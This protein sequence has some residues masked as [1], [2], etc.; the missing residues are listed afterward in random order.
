MIKKL[1]ALV[2]AAV[3][4]V[5]STGNFIGFAEN[6]ENNNIAVIFDIDGDGEVTAADA[7]VTLRHA[8]RIEEIVIPEI[9]ENYDK[10]LGDLN[11]DGEIDSADARLLLR[12][13]AKLETE[14]DIIQ[15]YFVN[16]PPKTTGETTAEP[17][18]EPPA[19]PEPVQLP[20][21]RLLTPY[22]NHNLGIREIMV[23]KDD[24]ADTFRPLNGEYSSYPTFSALPKGTIDYITG[25][26]VVAEDEGRV[27]YILKSGR[28]ISSKFAQKLD[29]GYAL[30]TN[31]LAAA[32]C[33]ITKKST[34]I[35][36]KT[37]WQVPFNLTIVPQIYEKGYRDRIF[38]VTDFT[39]ETISLTFYYSDFI[40]GNFDFS[41][42]GVIKSSKL[43]KSE[44]D[45]TVTLELALKEKGEFYGYHAEIVDG[46][47][48]FSFMHRDKGISG[49]VIM[50]DPGH[51]GRDSGAV[52]E[53]GAVL[54]KTLDFD[55]AS[56]VKKHL[57]NAGATVKMTR[58][59]DVYS[60]TY[61]R[62]VSVRKSNPDAF[63]SIHC[64]S[65]TDTSTSGT[66]SFYYTAYSKSF[67]ASVHNSVVKAYR[68]KIYDKSR[69]A[70]H[71]DSVDR[72]VKFYP[73]G[74]TRVDECP[75]ILIECGFMSNAKE[76]GVLKN[77]GNRDI[78]AKAI[79]DGIIKYFD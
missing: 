14:E 16:P 74:V 35:Y 23:V 10:I 73:F 53:K 64:D 4:L 40:D 52:A 50:L 21:N 78:I 41:G 17:A 79:A 38:N 49:S 62:S 44:S 51:G 42:S 45:R 28:K 46:Y 71:Y 9:Y 26:T 13:A 57:E 20:V 65:S 5:L 55:I 47:F 33:D 8:A 61:D 22:E 18:T 7:R 31:R 72:A 32:K 39:G 24:Y 3:L 70:N 63:I 68:D 30:P 69:D 29:G 56:K 15:I 2:F 60:D 11:N 77:D 43:I 6:S 59:G 1:P 66:H 19:P 36:I 67:A 25:Q 48:K 27:Y 58:T 12:L 37:T 34:D 54:E 76:R 75:A